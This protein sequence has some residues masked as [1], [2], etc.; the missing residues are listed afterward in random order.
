[1]T[2]TP[3]PELEAKL[4]QHAA[5]GNQDPETSAKWIL[6]EIL[7]LPSLPFLP[8]DSW[9][10]DLLAAASECGVSLSNEALSREGFL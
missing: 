3:S 2:M 6:D 8:R 4:A 5:R 1:M 9:E 10:R 7:G